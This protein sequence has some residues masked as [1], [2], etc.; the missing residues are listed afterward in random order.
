MINW[1]PVS[2]RLPEESGEFLVTRYS[3]TFEYHDVEILWYND[4]I[5][6][7]FY[8]SEYG[9]VPIVGV[10]AWAMLPEPYEGEEEQ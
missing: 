9:D 6:F 2:E 5:G 4:E 1:I 7:H 10:T 8:D 3:L